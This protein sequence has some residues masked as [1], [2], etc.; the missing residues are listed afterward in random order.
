[1][2]RKRRHHKKTSRR[3]RGIHGTGSSLTV[4]PTIMNTA[5]FVGEILAGYI[6]ASFLD[7]K[8]MTNVMPDQPAIKHG[9]IMVVGGGAATMIKNHH[10]KAVGIGMALYGGVKIAEDTKVIG[11]IMIGNTDTIMENIMIGAAQE[12]PRAA[13]QIGEASQVIARLDEETLMNG[14]NEGNAEVMM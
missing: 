9:G 14:Y 5:V 6:A 4:K 12:E 10:V 8:F 1:M 13:I 7:N 11:D 2:A 3:R